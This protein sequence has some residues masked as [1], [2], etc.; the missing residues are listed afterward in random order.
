MNSSQT[1]GILRPGPSDCG[2]QKPAVP[3]T[4]VDWLQP[5]SSRKTACNWAPHPKRGGTWLRL[6]CRFLCSAQPRI[7]ASLRRTINQNPALT[8]RNKKRT[9]G[10]HPEPSEPDRNGP[11]RQ[12]RS[13][14]NRRNRLSAAQSAPSC[15]SGV[16]EAR[17]VARKRRLEC[18]AKAAATPVASRAI[19]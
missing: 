3:S 5:T 9:C 12:F 4:R 13:L 11:F 18:P 2:L 8:H 14:R 10:Y 6:P 7:Y 1:Y 19:R 16:D 15:R 17:I